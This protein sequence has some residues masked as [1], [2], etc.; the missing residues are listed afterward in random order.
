MSTT[1]IQIFP[2]GQVPNSSTTIYTSTGV[3]TIIDKVSL[4]NTSGS[5]VT[6]SA[7]IVEISESA[8]A[9]NQLV[10]KTLTPG[11]VYSCPELVGQILVN[12]SFINVTAGAATSLTLMISGRVIS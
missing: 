4:L 5:N 2:A 12:G 6:F 10:S 9:D 7:N 1:V 11:Q 8:G 3:K